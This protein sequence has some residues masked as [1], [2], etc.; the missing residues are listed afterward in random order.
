MTKKKNIEIDNSEKAIRKPRKASSGPL[1]DKERTKA[2]MVAAVGKVIQKK[3]TPVL[4]H[5]ILPL[6]QE[7]INN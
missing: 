3:V 2:R 4:P 1:R 7:L 5:Q 6:Q